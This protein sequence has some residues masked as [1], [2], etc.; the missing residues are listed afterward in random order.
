MVQEALGQRTVPLGAK[1]DEPL[2][3]RKLDTKEHGIV[4]RIIFTLEEGRV[5][6]RH[7][8]GWTIECEK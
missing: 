7:A 6:D 4:Y 5:P 8:R 1:A 3:T 2:Q